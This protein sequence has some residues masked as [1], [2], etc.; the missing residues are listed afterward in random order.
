MTPDRELIPMSQRELHRYHTLRLVLERRI[1]GAQ[2][3][4]SLGLGL[5]HVGRALAE[6][7]AGEFGSLG[8]LAEADEERL[9]AVPDV[10][11]EVAS[12][13]R[14]WFQSKANLRLI[15][16]L[17]RHG[18][19][20]KAARPASEGRLAGKTFVITGELASMSR[21]EAENLVRQAGGKAAG[22]VSKNTDYLVVGESPGGTKMRAAEKHG[23]RI[24]DQTEFLKIV[25]K[26]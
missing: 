18:L 10:G 16:K 23:T 5:R 21:E 9:L 24:I 19:D 2:A 26:R 13:V 17:K 6:T 25:G 8:A 7:L 12:A 15:E 11:P 1:T 22:S 20:P 3:A 4:R 14:E